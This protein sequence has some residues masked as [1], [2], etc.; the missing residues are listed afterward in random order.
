MAVNMPKGEG[1]L[2]N[3]GRISHAQNFQPMLVVGECFATDDVF[4]V[5]PAGRLKSHGLK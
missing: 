1:L 2:G 3:T 4:A 5:K